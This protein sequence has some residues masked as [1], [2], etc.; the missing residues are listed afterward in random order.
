MDLLWLI[1]QGHEVRGV[2]CS[3]LAI[4]SFLSENHIIS[5]QYT[6]GVFTVSTGGKLSLFQGDY[7]KLL[8]SQVG[9]LD[10][11]F[12]RAALIALPKTMRIAY[13]Q[14]L[15]QFLSEG[16]RILLITLEYNQ[17]SMQGPPF[18]V[19][20]NEV[21][22]LYS[23]KFSIEKLHQQEIINNEDRFK[24]L[25]LESLIETVYCLQKM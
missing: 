22:Q 24:A 19:D 21:Y 23:D 6:D 12:D 16:G 2:E 3:K 14:H 8:C 18:S 1:E 9:D 7:F 10:Y 20:E 11:V 25:V 13:V 15:A 5:D 4:D 17:A